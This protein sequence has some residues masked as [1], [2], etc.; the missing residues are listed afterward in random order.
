MTHPKLP[1]IG[2]VAT[3]AE[4]K[5]FAET[6]ARE[7][8]RLV[9]GALIHDPQGRIYVQRRGPGRALFPN[10]WDIVGGHV[11]PGEELTA[12]LARE[13][14]EETRWRLK[15]V[16]RVV[17]I[18]DWSAGDGVSRREIDL[19]T[20]VD[21]DLANPYLEPDKHSEGRWLEPGELPMLLEGRNPDDRWVHDVVKRAFELLERAATGGESPRLR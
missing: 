17:E 11:D 6:A 14:A 3:E 9:V 10:C 8:R 12:A 1:Q 16:G 2:A 5:R 18:L 7:G 15:G 20:Q 4:L 13:I 21:G 19:L